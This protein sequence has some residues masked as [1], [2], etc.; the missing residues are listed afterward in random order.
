MKSFTRILTILFLSF[1][2]VFGLLACG[3][4][5]DETPVEPDVEKFEIVL[6]TVE[7]GSIT[8]SSSSVEE[9]G[10]VELTV[11]PDTNYELEYLKAN[12]VALTVTENKATIENVTADQTITASFIGVEMTVTFVVDGATLEESKYRFGDAYGTLPTATAPSGYEFA[13]WYTEESGAGNVVTAESKVSVGSNHSIYA[14]FTL[15]PLTVNVSGIVDKLVHLPNSESETATISVTVLQDDVDITPDA[16]I[17]LES[18]DPNLVVVDGLTLKIADAASGVAHI[19]VLV[20][21]QEYESFAVAVTDYVGLGYQ[22]VSTKEEFLAMNGNSKYLLTADIDLEGAWLSNTETWRSLIDTLA[23]E[24]VI[25]GNGHVVKNAKLASGWNNGWIN[26]LYGNVKNIV[27]LNIDSPNN[28]PYATGLVAFGKGGTLENIY[29]QMNLIYDGDAGDLWKSGGTLVGALEEGHIKNCVVDVLV[30]TGLTINNYGAIAAVANSWNGSIENTYAIVHHSGIE[31]CAGE[32]A[33]GVWAFNVKNESVATFDSVYSFVTTVGAL[34][35]FDDNWEFS[36]EGLTVF[37][38]KVLTSEEALT[39]SLQ[40]SF[41]FDITE[42]SCYIDLAVYRYGEL[43]TDFNAVYASND[44]NV[45]TTTT[46]GAIIFTGLGTATLTVVIEDTITLTSEI[47]ISEETK[48]VDEYT[49]ISTLEEWYTLIALNPD[50][51]FKLAN[52]ID[53]AG[54]FLVKDGAN[55]VT[56]TFTGELDGCGYAIKNAWLSGGWNSGLIRYQAGTIKNIAFVNMHSTDVV[57]ETA[58][59]AFNR[60]TIENVYLDMTIWPARDQGGNG[61]GTLVGGVE[62]NSTIKNCIVNV[63]KSA[64]DTVVSGYGAIVGT[65]YSWTG[66]VQN[67]F[68]ITNDTGLTSIAY[69]EVADGLINYMVND[70]KSNTFENYSL[71]K[72]SA[73]LSGYDSTIWSFTETTI[74]FGGVVVLE[75]V[76]HVCDFSGEWKSD[77][78]GH[79]HECSCG[80]TDEKVAHSGGN[81]TETEKAVCEVCGASYGELVQPE[82]KVVTILIQNNWFWTD[83]YVH[84]WNDSEGTEWPGVKLEPVGTND[85]KDLYK[86]EIDAL[87]YPNFIING[88]DQGG[89]RNQTKNLVVLDYYEA[90]LTD[91]FYIM[92]NDTENNNYIDHFTPAEGTIHLHEYSYKSD[93]EQHWLECSC[94]V[95]SGEKV[96]H[97]GGEATITEKAVCEVCGASYGEVKDLLISTVEEWL[98][99]IP[100][101]PSANIKLTADLD[102][103]GGYISGKDATYLVN[104]FYGVLDGQ[105]HKILNAKLPGGWAGHA[106]IS[107]N[108]GIIKNIAFI[109]LTGN[110]VSTDLGIVA[111]NKA[112]IENLY[113]D[114][115][116]VSGTYGS[117]NGVVASFADN[118]ASDA[119]PSEIRNCIVNVRLAEGATLPPGQ[120]SIIGKAGGWNG[121]VKNC[122]AIINDTAITNVYINEGASGVGDYVCGTSA[123]FTTYALLKAAADV[124]MYDAAIWSFTD[125]TIS[126]FGNVVYEVEA[127]PVDEYTYIS[128]VEEWLALI[129][130]NPAGKFKLANNLD[131]ENGFITGANATYLTDTF[132]G[133][134]DGQGYSISN[135]KIPGGWAGHAIFNRNEGIIRNIAFLN[136]TANA[137]TSQT[138]LINNNLGVIENLYVDYVFV[139]STYESTYNGVIAALANNPVSGSDIPSEI[140]NCIIN[141]RFADGATLPSNQGSIIG[142]AGGWYGFVKNCYVMTNNT[143]VGNIYF[144]EAADGVAAYACGTSAQFETYALLKAGADLSMYDSTLWAFTDTTISFGGV[145]VYSAE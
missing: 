23:A 112:V 113:V 6:P 76:P 52:D 30:K 87:Q 97:S 130:A 54:G 111:T 117:N 8:A 51:K 73:D 92:H 48:P 116:I 5:D 99:L 2:L 108:F 115:V 40:D 37:G 64:G 132:T 137:V 33:E 38:N 135:A 69:R 94:G 4:K 47:T 35:Q 143:G 81:A 75:Y 43:S 125:T 59:F 39:A 16:N 123:Q 17:V 18:S 10:S 140:R 100:A 80:A 27:F 44:E 24:A 41:S 60:G 26:N 142:K 42:E 90:S 72:A 88:Y 110:K 32:V 109:N 93:D 118:P 138:A 119:Y 57:Y 79:W 14:H 11:T 22:T 53:V 136:T 95:V 104:E 107:K 70:F 50:G 78:E 45:F 141:V 145:V 25:D 55:F 66:L 114:Y 34:D 15:A 29:L 139:T 128:T 133:V 89:Y 129:P 21:G 63:K 9:G 98:T 19:K 61:A 31:A 82:T 1:G 58:L 62:E 7:H 86:I 67:S 134:L 144:S 96:A 121:F 12:D 36:E 126:F 20:N 124:S 28:Y 85:G 105:G 13:G 83:F 122:Y 127:A 68:A 91:V 77:E 56:E 106:M 103:N 101:N 3:S 65:L 102:F 131:F 120:G 74:S 84:Y 71:L 46:D 49:Y